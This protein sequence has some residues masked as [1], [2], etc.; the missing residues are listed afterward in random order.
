MTDQRKK[1]SVTIIAYRQESTNLHRG[2]RLFDQE[3]I[4]RPMHI[5]AI[6]KLVVQCMH[7]NI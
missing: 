4:Y 2:Y 3:Y 6:I 1:Y 5:F 7:G